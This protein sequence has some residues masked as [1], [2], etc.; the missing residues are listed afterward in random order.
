M[1]NNERTAD[2][3]TAAMVILLG[4]EDI[5]SVTAGRY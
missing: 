2:T 1:V 5:F 4:C 3:M